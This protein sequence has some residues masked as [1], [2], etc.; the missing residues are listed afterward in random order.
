MKIVID[1]DPELYDS[2]CILL[3][4]EMRDWERRYSK[5]GWGWIYPLGEGTS[6]FVRR[7]THGLSLKQ[8][9]KSQ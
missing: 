7:I 1:C 5:V 2:A 3:S 6:C 4:R 8:T 9:A